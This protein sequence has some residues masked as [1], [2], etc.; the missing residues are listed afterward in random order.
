MPS[1]VGHAIIGYAVSREMGF[2]S[3]KSLLGA[4]LATLPDI[5]IPVGLLVKRDL[6]AL[7]RQGTHSLAFA[8]M[9][10]LAAHLLHRRLRPQ[11]GR[12]AA[13]DTGLMIHVAVASH[14]VADK[15]V[16][17]QLNRTEEFNHDR[18]TKDLKQTLVW[19]MLNV[20][21]DVLYFGIPALWLARRRPRRGVA[22]PAAGGTLNRV[23]PIP[24]P[25]R[26]G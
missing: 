4:A 19:E 17:P 21:L 6:F 13:V 22:K 9:T 10:G 1:P 14:V 18:A 25:A 5:D 23:G 15:V 3:R 12:D 11:H 26:P 7:H 24:T 20:G 8:G 2:S 16:W